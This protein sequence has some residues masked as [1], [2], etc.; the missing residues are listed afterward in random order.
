MMRISLSG[1]LLP[2]KKITNW[3]QLEKKFLLIFLSFRIFQKFFW[4]YFYKI[5]FPRQI[6]SNFWRVIST[7][8]QVS[9]VGGFQILQS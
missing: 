1:Y 4:F 3:L 2:N 6:Q 9:I 8:P 5:R 7:F